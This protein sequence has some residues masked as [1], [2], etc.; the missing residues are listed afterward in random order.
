[1]QR[2]LWAEFAQE[3]K[4]DQVVGLELVRNSTASF[5]NLAIALLDADSGF[6]ISDPRASIRRPPL[7]RA[8]K[9]A[10]SRS[11]SLSSQHR[12]AR[13]DAKREALE[14]KSSVKSHGQ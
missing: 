10:R 4:V 12:I 1:M 3:V 6:G 11:D 7:G 14:L 8:L 5:C 13:R 9:R 2:E